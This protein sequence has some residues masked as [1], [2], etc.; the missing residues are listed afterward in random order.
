MNPK[1]CVVCEFAVPLIEE[2]FR[3]ENVTAAEAYAKGEKFCSKIPQPAGA[4]CSLFMNMKGQIL[5]QMIEDGAKPSVVC[6][7]S[8]ICPP[9]ALLA[10][11]KAVSGCFICEMAIPVIEGLAHRM[12]ITAEHAETLGQD[13]CKHLHNPAKTVCLIAVKTKGKTVIKDIVNGAPARKACHDMD[14]C[15][16]TDSAV[17]MAAA[18]EPEALNL[19][20][21]HACETAIPRI[22][23]FMK[24]HNITKTEA[25]TMGVKL[26]KALPLPISA[27]CEILVATKGRKVLGEIAE[28]APAEK[29]CTDA[30]VVPQD[31][32]GADVHAHRGGRAPLISSALCVGP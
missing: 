11:E 21:C 31:A 10:E 12:N 24:K 15:K 26:C 5:F 2:Y 3:L 1:A 17:V 23:H 28:G 14:L 32:D 9:A 19:S 18:Q 27:I 7:A 22:E 13:F 20:A 4:I 8:G 25:V 29:V 6:G 16:A 30:G